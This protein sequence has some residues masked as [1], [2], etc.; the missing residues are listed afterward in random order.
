M[1]TKIM[2]KLVNCKWFIVCQCSECKNKLKLVF[3]FVFKSEN[4]YVFIVI[5]AL[6]I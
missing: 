4:N 6:C 1:K 2:I 5:I 3:M